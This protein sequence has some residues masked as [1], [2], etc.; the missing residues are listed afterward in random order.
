MVAD[1]QNCI[2]VVV[3][4]NNIVRTTHTHTHTH[5]HT[6]K[7]RNLLQLLTDCVAVLSQHGRNEV[8]QPFIHLPNGVHR[9]LISLNFR[10]KMKNKY[11]CT[12]FV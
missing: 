2:F 6:H 8:G 1:E 4:R 10:F 12:T 3:V 9:G 11:M 5:M 7:Q